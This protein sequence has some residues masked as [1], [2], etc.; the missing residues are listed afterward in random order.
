[1]PERLSGQ[2]GRSMDEDTFSALRAHYLR[3]VLRRYSTLS[4]PMSVES[5]N[6]PSLAMEAIV[7]PL[8]LRHDPFAVEDLDQET[9]EQRQREL[10]W[11]H[12][13]RLGT[14]LNN[15]PSPERL[16]ERS[17]GKSGELGARPTLIATNTAEA[18]AR[19]DRRRM[20]ILGGPGSGKTTALKSLVSAAARRAL[21]ALS[22][23]PESREAPQLSELS[24]P[25]AP[26]PLFI[27]LPDLARSGMSSEQPIVEYFPAAL[28]E[29]GVSGDFAEVLAQALMT[30][31][32]LVCLDSLDEVAPSDRS[33][34]IVRINAW[35]ARPGGVWVVGSRFTEY[36]GGQF[37]HANFDEWELEPLNP[38]TRLEVARRLLPALRHRASDSTDLAAQASSGDTLGA[39]PVSS[40]VR[41]PV[42][43]LP[44]LSPTGLVSALDAH[45][46]AAEWGRNP[47]L[48]SLAAVVYAQSGALPTS[49]AALYS[50]ILGAALRTREQDDS[51]RYSELRAVVE[52]VALQLFFSRGRAFTRDDLI[53]QLQQIRQDTDAAW[54][55][56][57]MAERT[58]RSGALEPVARDTYVFC[59]QTF[60]EYLAAVALARGLMSVD[61]RQRA[62]SW[63]LA[64]GKRTYSRWTDTLRLM[65]GVLAHDFGTAGAREAARWLRA[66]VS[67]RRAVAGGP[68]DLE[69][70]LALKS[71]REAPAVTGAESTDE[72]GSAEM[73]LG[74]AVITA[75]VEEM[76]AALAG[77]SVARQVRLIQMMRGE[78][79]LLP[80]D[81]GERVSQTLQPTLRN[82]PRQRYSQDIQVLAAQTLGELEERA[83]A[84][85]LLQVV[86]RF[87]YGDIAAAAAALG[88]M[89]AAAPIDQLI[90]AARLGHVH[91]EDN[92]D[93]RRLCGNAIRALGYLGDHAPLDVLISALSSDEF[94]VPASE[95]LGMLGE[96]AIPP[97]L[98]LARSTWYLKRWGAI[99]ALG[100]MGERAPIAPLV[101]AL[102]DVNENVRMYA[103]Y[104]LAKMG[105]RAPIDRMV[106]ALRDDSR[107]VADTA[108]TC[109]ERL[110]PHL[111]VEPFL[112][113][114]EDAN[115]LMRS[116]A[117][118]ILGHMGARAPVERIIALLDDSPGAQID[119]ETRRRAF[120]S[121]YMLKDS[122]PV[123][124]FIAALADPALRSR[125]LTALGE[126]GARAPIEPL[127]DALHAADGRPPRDLIYALACQAP[128][129][130]P[131]LLFSSLT[132]QRIHNNEA[133]QLVAVRALGA[134]DAPDGVQTGSAARALLKQL[135]GRTPG[136]RCAAAHALQLADSL[137]DGEVALPV[138]TRLAIAQTLLTT[139]RDNDRVVSD[140][141]Q[142]SFA[143]LASVLPEQPLVAALHET[144]GALQ[145]WPTIAV[146]MGARTPLEPLVTALDHSDAS[147]REAALR[148]LAAIGAFLPDEIVNGPVRDAI[149]RALQQSE[150]RECYAAL[151]ALRPLAKRMTDTAIFVV[152]T[153][154]DQPYA[155]QVIEQLLP[156]LGQEA[157][158]PLVAPMVALVEGQAPTRRR[159]AYALHML[160]RQGVAV[161]L[162]PLVVQLSDPDRDAAWAARRAI[163][164]CG[165]WAPMEP[166][167]H[168]LTAPSAF[169]RA[170]AAEALQHHG[171]RAPVEPLVAALNDVDH[172]VQLEA[173]QALIAC[174]ARAFPLLIPL[175]MSERA[176]HLRERALFALSV[177]WRDTPMDVFVR[178]SR[179]AFM[180]MRRR[181]VMALGDIV[182]AASDMPHGED[183]VS[184][185]NTTESGRAQ[186]REALIQA[187]E[188]PHVTVREHAFS[189]LTKA[190]VAVPRETIMPH[191]RSDDWRVRVNAVKAI[192]LRREMASVAQLV[193]ILRSHGEAE[194]RKAAA[195]AL[196]SLARADALGEL[197]TLDPLRT[198]LRDDPDPS[199]R[200]AAFNAMLDLYPRVSLDLLRVAL[201]DP[202]GRV[203]GTSAAA[204]V[205]LHD[206]AAIPALVSMLNDVDSPT[207][208]G[209]CNALLALGQ[210]AV[211]ALVAALKDERPLLRQE[212]ARALNKLTVQIISQ[213][214][215]VDEQALVAGDPAAQSP[216][217][218][219]P[220]DL[221]H[222][223]ELVESALSDPDDLTRAGVAR[224]LSYWS[225]PDD[226]RVG[227]WLKAALGD[228][229]RVVRAEA[230]SSLKNLRRTHAN[231]L[232]A[233]VSEALSAL[234]GDNVGG[235]FDALAESYIARM[236]GEVIGDT[237]RAPTALITLLTDLLH[238]P[239]WQP[240]SHAAQAIG[241]LRRGVPD[242]AIRRLMELRSKGNL[243][244]DHQAADDALALV[245]SLET[246]I[247]D[248]A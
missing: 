187:L 27:S 170:A 78:L 109:L 102:D 106:D 79:A 36:R 88:R 231:M 26:L 15:T 116:R 191:L 83:P 243:Q 169:A 11:P 108:C 19:S 37:A 24:D 147:V 162:E 183:Y 201:D 110:A 128:R 86:M 16:L 87:E 84:D 209:A 240:R 141:A 39:S 153:S 184:G 69:L 72:N 95:A 230:L 52:V 193:E 233:L 75:W 210:R 140:E 121:L 221:A 157:L 227:R 111:P 172:D 226:P 238:H 7:Q 94:F 54:S 130:P 101:A 151:R 241:K 91:F 208:N 77:G 185:A 89:G 197:V 59:H 125:A 175:T 236:V 174:E 224:A 223:A 217:L 207:R 165:D 2:R 188:D 150:Q 132:D 100:A 6:A 120:A 198:A 35:A 203:R 32:A 62:M 195:A 22:G 204:L 190:G 199:V 182:E 46:H 25:L 189:S 248:E 12:T 45:S 129:I 85:T 14:T 154:L 122:A 168:A 222:L 76:Q 53:A 105:E 104:A 98:D 126:C 247:E 29:L 66:L 56:N 237:G 44:H 134:A 144:S 232:L 200:L 216:N 9:Y 136:V 92:D 28:A 176:D 145:V 67:Q 244:A 13:S 38:A 161:P 142:E 239:H 155:E 58:L 23:P 229:S 171:K 4:L 93:E 113:L 124:P 63:E 43:N 159:A 215:S 133:L 40:P 115:P 96:R 214:A 107:P 181:A 219:A 48:F 146:A 50:A 228:S 202:E 186:A 139:M 74:D 148:A 156:L 8:R 245:L 164:A 71:L 242:E 180:P 49:R 160:A 152:A 167:L 42:S 177:R 99:M 179:D 143:A 178:A 55:A 17:Q 3:A 123:E 65:V 30:G 212:A 213:I 61:L 163:S 10:Q 234:Q 73:S 206:E 51:T 70:A 57:E 149:L 18:L 211:A 135:S 82:G 235:C 97:L 114:L 64:W 158:E 90:E 220:P 5:V 103:L 117:L 68:G 192:S 246:G 118:D 47:L 194:M 80:P 196:G 41:P 119:A 131:A 34:M 137:A 138:A 1:M 205:A 31:E 33:Q 218:A 21:T 166:L 112:S 127:L 20:V 60:Q 81:Q 173:V 225:D